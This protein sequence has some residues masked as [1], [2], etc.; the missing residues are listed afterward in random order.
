MGWAT[1]SRLFEEV[2]EIVGPYLDDD[3]KIDVVREMIGLFEG[4]DCDTLQEVEDQTVQDLLEEMYG[5][6]SNVEGIYCKN[7]PIM[8]EVNEYKNRASGGMYFVKPDLSNLGEKLDG[9]LNYI[10]SMDPKV[11]Q[12]VQKQMAETVYDQ[13]SFEEVSK[14]VYKDLMRAIPLKYAGEGK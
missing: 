6:C 1:G 9:I 14:K 11:Q 4:Y 3:E 13:S 2:L 5:G 12:M 10:Q 8:P 7:F